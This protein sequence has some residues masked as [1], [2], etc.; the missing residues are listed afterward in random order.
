[1]NDSRWKSGCLIVAIMIA[2]SV[3]VFLGLEDDFNSPSITLDTEVQHQA[4]NRA[5]SIRDNSI[6]QNTTWPNYRVFENRADSLAFAKEQDEDERRAEEEKRRAEEEERKRRA[7]FTWHATYFVDEWGERSSDG[8]TSEPAAPETP[9]EWPY[10]D[11]VAQVMVQCKGPET[12][13]RFTTSPNLTGGDTK[14]GHNVYNLPVRLDGQTS[15]WRT[16]QRWGSEDINLPRS[17]VNTFKQSK[18]FEIVLPW[19]GSGNVRFKWDLKGSSDII[20]EA[21]N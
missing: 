6:I 19:F 11:V 1:M 20:S 17:A 3:I 7:S 2:A 15:R 9:M 5:D 21:C 10:S 18:T 13:I 16:T 4:K 8:A 12:W 14:M